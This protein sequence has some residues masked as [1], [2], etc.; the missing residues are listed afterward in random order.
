[1]IAPVEAFPHIHGILPTNSFGGAGVLFASVE[2]ENLESKY[3][4]I[5]IR[6]T[7]GITLV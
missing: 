3:S 7:A 4:S 6:K 1:M 5:S 2:E